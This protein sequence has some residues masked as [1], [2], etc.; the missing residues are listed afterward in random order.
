[1]SCSA[2]CFDSFDSVD[3]VDSFDIF[4]KLEPLRQKLVNSLQDVCLAGLVAWLDAL[5]FE[6]VDA[7]LDCLLVLHHQLVDVVEPLVV[8]ACCQ[9]TQR[10][11]PAAMRQ[12]AVVVAEFNQQ[13]C[14]RHGVVD[15]GVLQAFPSVLGSQADARHILR[16]CKLFSCLLVGLMA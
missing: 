7:L 16:Q 13:A 1:M 5:Q 14:C 4:V 3:S 2:T 10:C 12:L 15:V 6:L 9:H 11:K 8:P